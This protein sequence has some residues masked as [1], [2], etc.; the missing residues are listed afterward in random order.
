MNL[1]N[2]TQLQNLAVRGLKQ[3]QAEISQSTRKLSLGNELSSELSTGTD[4]TKLSRLLSQVTSLKAAVRNVSESL[5]ALAVADIAL[6]EVDNI[7]NRVRAI[8]VESSSDG[9]T[10]TDRTTMESETSALINE[11]ESISTSTA[12]NNRLLLDGSFSGINAQV[13]P[14]SNDSVNFSVTTSKPSTLGAYASIG[15]TRDALAAAATATANSTTTSENIIFTTESGSTTIDVGNNESAKTVAENIN[16]VTATTG[17]S[18]QAKTYALLFSTSASAENYTISINGS[19][20][21][22][23]TISNSSV[24]DAVS[25]INL[26]S[27]ST[28]VTATTNAS[29]QVLLHDIDG[30][31]ITIEN[32]S[33]NTNL[34]VQAVKYDGSTTQG[35]AVSLAATNSNDATR[36]IGTLR[37]TSATSFSVTQSGDTSLGYASTGTPSLSTLSTVS[38]SSSSNASLALAVIDGAINQVAEIRGNLGALENRFLF[39][40]SYLEGQKI[41]KEIAMGVISDV[42]VASESAKLAKAM[43]MQEINTALL[44]Q[45]NSGTSLLTKLLNDAA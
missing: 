30:D 8:A 26:V 45:A 40:E 7:L 3:S 6:D 22:S 37:L 15:P 31:D 4:S 23:F 43:V 19:A 9:M 38:M 18:A 13:G 16:G 44:A 1:S 32:T 25:K 10:S 11:I 33:A 35:N 27:A 41:T 17:V 34:D 14:N 20:I 29:N 5:S 36:I 2:I 42:D 28:G 12:Y 24:S 21:S 39:S